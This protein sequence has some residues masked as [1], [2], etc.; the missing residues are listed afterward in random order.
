MTL[1]PKRGKYKWNIEMK[2][3][4]KTH[5]ITE[6]IAQANRDRIDAI[7]ILIVVG[8]RKALVWKDRRP[9][10]ACLPDVTG[11]PTLAS[12]HRPKPREQIYK[13]TAK[14]PSGKYF[15]RSARTDIA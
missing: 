11:Q 10:P 12:G 4:L 14:K 6:I 5:D 9:V 1:Y 2:N 13:F 15:E 7:G 8:T 3:E